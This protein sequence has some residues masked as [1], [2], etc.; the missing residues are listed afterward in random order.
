MV[1]QSKNSQNYNHHQRLVQR[2]LPPNSPTNPKTLPLQKTVVGRCPGNDPLAV[3]EVARE[4]P[5]M[6]SLKMGGWLG[7]S[8]VPWIIRPTPSENNLQWI[9][10][11]G[12]RVGQL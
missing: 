11:A 6:L 12:K 1:K 8:L 2:C 4:N 5:P 9:I 10:L 7:S 3:L